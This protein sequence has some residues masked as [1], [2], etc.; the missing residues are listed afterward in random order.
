M[1]R[2]NFIN[3]GFLYSFKVIFKAFTIN[4]TL[5]N[6]EIEK[7]YFF[8]IEKNLKNLMLTLLDPSRL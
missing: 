7:M 5:K 3:L 8:S 2:S 4:I 6:S 1:F